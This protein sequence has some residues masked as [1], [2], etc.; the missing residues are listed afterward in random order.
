MKTTLSSLKADFL[1]NLEIGQGRSGKTAHNYDYYLTR[2]FTHQKVGSLED[3][4]TDRIRTFRRWL[5]Q[6][7]GED[8]KGVMLATSNYYFIAL[9]QF[10]KYLAKRDIEALSP[11][12]IELAKLPERDIDVLYPE[13][14]DQLLASFHPKTIEDFRDFALVSLLFSTGIRISEAAKL[15]RDDIREA[16]SEI[17]VRG[18]GNKIRV[19]FLSQA[20]RDAIAA[21]TS[22]RGDVDGALFIR[23]KKGIGAQDDL[24]LTT[25]TMQR[26]IKKRAQAA[27]ITKD[28]TP[29]TLRH[30]FA[31]DLLSN[32]ADIRHVQQLLGHSSITTTQIYTHITDTQLRNIH[33]Q[34]HNLRE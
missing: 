21:Y 3:I 16:H 28:I 11:D 34:Y 6:E 23:H 5:N 24:R 27:G 8:G 7:A 9:R 31:T 4:T 13:E 2:F 17:T 15:N 20:A 18:K 30:S 19:V 10:L 32:G 33:E 25:R 14:M 12:K 26:V 22:K 1:E 29:H